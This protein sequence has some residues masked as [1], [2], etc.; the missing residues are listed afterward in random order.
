[1]TLGT[2]NMNTT[3]NIAVLQPRVYF[4]NDFNR[5][6]VW[7]GIASSIADAGIDRPAAAPG[8]PSE[9]SGNV[10]EGT[11]LI[12][13]YYRD[14]ASPAG[15]G[16][17]YGYRSNLSD[18]LSLAVSAGGQKLTFSVGT[19]GSDI[20]RSTDP[21]VDT[22]VLVMTAVGGTEFFIA[23]EVANSGVASVEIDVSDAVLIVGTSLV[24]VGDAFS[25]DKPPLAAQLAMCRGYAFASVYHDA[26]VTIGVTNGSTTVTA[27]AGTFST[28]WAGRL[29]TV[30]GGS[31]SYRIASVASATS[32]TLAIAYAGSTNATAS[33]VIQTTAP[34]RVYWSRRYYPES[35][36]IATQAIDVLRDVDDRIV[37]ITEYLGDPW[38]MGRRTAQRVVFSNDPAR[39]DIVTVSGENGVFNARCVVKPDNDT[40]MAWGSNGVW[41]VAGGRPAHISKPIDDAWRAILNYD[42]VD[43]IHG[44]YDPEDQEVKWAFCAGTSTT[45]NRVLVFDTRGRRWRIDL[46]RIGLNSATIITESTGRIRAAVSDA[47]NGMTYVAGGQTDGVP[48][49]DTLQG[50]HVV[51]SGSTTTATVVTA[52]LVTGGKGAGMDGLSIYSPDLDETVYISSNTSTT[53]THGAFSAALTPGQLVYIGSIPVDL[54]WA[55]WPGQDQSIEKIPEKVV[56]YMVPSTVDTRIEVRQHRDFGSSAVNIPVV[57]GRTFNRGVTRLPDG[58]AV[59]MSTSGGYVEIPTG[60]APAKVFQIQLTCDDPTGELT[61]LDVGFKSGDKAP[62]G[63]GE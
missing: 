15:D 17:G 30:D 2:L 24:S 23:A 13:Y 25:H 47:T 3:P 32:L 16:E 55:W 26:R 57:V 31:K 9:S 50:R 61:I 48:T 35:W 40:M 46:Y 63:D 60:A 42:E 8:T 34:N 29:L 44:W 33:A 10:T 45:P 1:M 39:A 11:H 14:S 37:A 20:V 36:N 51:G 12:G 49:S 22:I 52:P 18:T 27:G 4:A 59:D 53:I 41:S 62:G 5:I 38:V 6:Q 54:Q 7:D 28:A 19:T 43:R 56:L 21:K 58:F